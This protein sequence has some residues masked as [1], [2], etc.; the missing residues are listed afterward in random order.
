MAEEIADRCNEYIEANA[1][2]YDGMP[3]EEAVEKLAEAL[4]RHANEL[5]WEP[6]EYHLDVQEIAAAGLRRH[7][8][9]S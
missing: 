3:E 8:D 2:S 6:L 9:R 4:K 5:G 1:A 7:R